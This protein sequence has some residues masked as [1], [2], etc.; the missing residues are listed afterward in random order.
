MN[1]ILMNVNQ[2]G[3]LNG[4]KQS[5]DNVCIRWCCRGV[6]SLQRGKREKLWGLQKGANLVLFFTNIYSPPLDDITFHQPQCKEQEH[7]IALWRRRLLFFPNETSKFVVLLHFG[8]VELV[9]NKL[10]T[11][12]VLFRITFTRMIILNLLLKE[13]TV[14]FLWYFLLLL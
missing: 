11:T 14:P 5:T 6:C 9:H 8:G 4:H 10:S 1:E 2:T 3:V 13:R 7:T 12:T